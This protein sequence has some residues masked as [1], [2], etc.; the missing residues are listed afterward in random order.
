MILVGA[1]AAIRFALGE[2]PDIESDGNG[3]RLA[4]ALAFL[5]SGRAEFLERWGE[6]IWDYAVPLPEGAPSPYPPLPSL[7]LAPALLFAGP[8]ATGQ[9]LAAVTALVLLGLGTLRA[10]RATGGPWGGVIATALALGSPVVVATSRLPCGEI[11]AAAAMA[12]AVGAI[13]DLAAGRGE[14]WEAGLALGAAL[15]AKW[16]NAP[17]LA[18]PALVLAVAASRGAGWRW[19]L[20]T[21][22]L[23]LLEVGLLAGAAKGA[24]AAHV[25]GIVAVLGGA[26]IVGASRAVR[27]QPGVAAARVLAVGNALAAPWYGYAAT[28]ILA[29]V[30][31]HVA[32]SVPAAPQQAEVFALLAVYA[33]TPGAS[34]FLLLGLLG[35]A[36]VPGRLA[37]LGVAAAAL[38]GLWGAFAAGRVHGFFTGQAQD[39]LLVA[40]AVL[41]ACF[42]ARGALVWR[43]GPLVGTAALAVGLVATLAPHLGAGGQ[44]LRQFHGARS[45]GVSADPAE[46][47]YR[48]LVP[49]LA[50][51]SGPRVGQADP[52]LEALVAVLP[53]RDAPMLTG[54][55]FDA[56]DCELGEGRLLR[57]AETGRVVSVG[58]RA[59]A[60]VIRAWL[61]DRAARVDE[62]VAWGGRSSDVLSAVAAAE[63]WPAP[64]RQGAVAVAVPGRAP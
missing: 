32:A 57:L 58:P 38:V 3:L 59:D 61:R 31:G 12:W 47:G 9:R 45:C 60:E 1:L 8:G 55:L 35:V 37:P 17:L 16:T 42:A 49:G 14:G 39:R 10:G 33:C 51:A 27:G 43:L 64:V 44:P 63:G 7:V 23:G 20:A 25:P 36:W 56:D 34:S 28:A 54:L 19:G 13:V 11:V 26:L 15:L 30:E 21:V 50:I 62:F 52:A 2:G 40:Y 29:H 4:R 41:A 5:E 6:P 22:G 18:A 46:R 48:W 53:R 24:V